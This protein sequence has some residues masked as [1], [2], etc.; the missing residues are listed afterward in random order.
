MIVNVWTVTALFLAAV[1]VALAVAAAAVALGGLRRGGGS[2]TERPSAL[3]AE[4]DRAHL[5]GLIVGVLAGMRLIAWPSA[6]RHTTT[7][8]ISST[9]RTC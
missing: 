2:D 4:E 3:A 1:G 5:L 9:A 6:L 8:R 7:T